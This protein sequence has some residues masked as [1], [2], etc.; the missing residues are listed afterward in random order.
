MMFRRPS[1]RFVYNYRK[2]FL[3]VS[4]RRFLVNV[5]TNIEL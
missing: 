1:A 4:H 3:K 5:T 2:I